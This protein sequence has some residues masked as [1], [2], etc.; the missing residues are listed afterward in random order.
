MDADATRAGKCRPYAS[1]LPTESELRNKC[2]IPFDVVAPEVIQQ[3]TATTHEHQQT[4]TAVM[5]LLVDLQVLREMVDTPRE[6]RNLHL[7][8]AGVGLVEA[9]LGD[10]CCGIGHAETGILQ[11][12]EAG[13]LPRRAVGGQVRRFGAVRFGRE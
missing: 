5:I 7:R 9:M 12:A 3:T 6:E 4:S 2:P 10:R 1:V 11:V 8:R 13:N